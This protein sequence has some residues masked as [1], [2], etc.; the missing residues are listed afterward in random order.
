MTEIFFERQDGGDGGAFSSSRSG[1]KKR[2]YKLIFLK[3]NKKY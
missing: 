3:K 2:G 1:V